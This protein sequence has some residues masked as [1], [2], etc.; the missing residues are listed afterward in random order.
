[1]IM[2]VQFQ[3]CE[4]ATLMQLINTDNK[5]L[6]KVFK[7]LAALCCEMEAL[8]NEAEQRFY[9]PLQYYGEG[10]QYFHCMAIM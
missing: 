4:H 2:I 9:H 10:G 1:M 7:V 5:N 8:Q 3:P 6:N